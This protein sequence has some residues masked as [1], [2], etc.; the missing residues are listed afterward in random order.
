MTSTHKLMARTVTV[1]EVSRFTLEPGETLDERV[2][3]ELEKAAENGSLKR[4]VTNVGLP[5]LAVGEVGGD[6][7]LGGGESTLSIALYGPDGTPLGDRRFRIDPVEGGHFI[8]V[9]IEDDVQEEHPIGVF[10]D[11]SVAEQVAMFWRN[12]HLNL[13]P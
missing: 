8:A 7:G 5:A 4:L 10:S 2:N 9:A 11:E 12:G 1:N 13:R 6:D 3:K